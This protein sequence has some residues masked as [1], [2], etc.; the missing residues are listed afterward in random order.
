MI[1][2]HSKV[3]QYKHWSFYLI[4]YETNSAVNFFTNNILIETSHTHAHTHAHTHTHTHTHTNTH[5]HTHTHTQT[6]THTHKNTHGT[7]KNSPL[8]RKKIQ[9]NEQPQKILFNGL[10]P[11]QRTQKEDSIVNHTSQ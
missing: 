11:F 5:T 10:C 9:D 7:S 1:T 3:S 4:M 2:V 8:I 6:H